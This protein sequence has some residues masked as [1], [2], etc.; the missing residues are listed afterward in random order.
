MADIPYKDY[1]SQMAPELKSQLRGVA[2]NTTNKQAFV[3]SP[4][5]ATTTRGSDEAFANPSPTSIVDDD[6][7]KY[8]YIS[9]PKDVTQD[10]AN[11]HYMLFY[12]NV[13]NKAG[14]GYDGADG[15]PVG[16]VVEQERKGPPDGKGGFE[17]TGQ[18]DYV[19]QDSDPVGYQNAFNRVAK[20]GKGNTLKEDQ[21][22]LTPNSRYQNSK[23]G[24]MGG[25]NSTYKTTTRITDSVAIYLPPNVEDK[26][27]ATYNDAATGVA[28]LVAAGGGKFLEAMKR[29]D[30]QAAASQLIGGVK[31][32]SEE[33]LIRSSAGIIDFIGGG[34]GDTLG[35]ANKIF[36]QAMNPYM[37]VIF[38]AMD[39]RSFTYN[40]TFAPKNTQERDDAQDI[41]KLFRFHMAPELKGAQHRF[42]T[43]PSTFDIHYMYQ[44][45]KEYASENN[46]YSKIATCVLQDVSVNYSPN[47]VK[48]FQDGSPTQITMSLQFKETELLTK[49]SINAGY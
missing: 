7:M 44:H 18:F 1:L 3:S 46:F 4:V 42:L 48:S 29:N 6:P 45:S 34:E 31:A 49:Q 27:S 36:G 12:V 14:Y 2:N 35:L 15:N 24:Q 5:S 10:M 11:G 28:G 39:M 17:S 43:L 22:F 33:A 16:G 23:Y 19:R 38:D 8:R 37:E 9:Y 41:I 20:G 26:T 13:Q 32:I 21:I 47:G 30:Y 40:F 25:V